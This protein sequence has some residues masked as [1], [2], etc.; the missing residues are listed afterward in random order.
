MRETKHVFGKDPKEFAEL[1]KRKLALFAEESVRMEE[2]HQQ[3]IKDIREESK[4]VSSAISSVTEVKT[5][6]V[7]LV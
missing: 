1:Q 3:R 4:R 7:S 6:E 5:Y 2:E